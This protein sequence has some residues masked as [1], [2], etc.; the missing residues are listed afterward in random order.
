MYS[1][2]NI[3]DAI[4]DLG[5]ETVQSF[6]SRFCCKKNKEIENFLKNC[7]ID[8]AK[9]KISVTHLAIDTHNQLLGYV[10][11]AHKPAQIDISHLSATKQKRLLRFAGNIDENNSNICVSAMLLAQFGKNS[12]VTDNPLTG[13]E[14]MHKALNL[15]VE[16]QKIIGG[17]V[18]FLECENIPQVM[19]FYE[20]HNFFKFSEREAEAENTRYNQLLRFLP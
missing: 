1:Y 6:F 18:V 5:E 17:G 8:F 12:A 14:L 2:V 7:A 19:K 3:L 20:S 15:F 13:T 16:A 9:K 4:D 11:L 10:T